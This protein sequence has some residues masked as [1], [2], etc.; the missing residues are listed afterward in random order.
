M[1]KESILTPVGR[2]VMGSFYKPQTTNI[3]GGP[4]TDKHGKPRVEYFFAI[5]IPKGTEN[6]WSQTPWG[7]KIYNAG[8]TGFPNGQT[9]SPTFAWKIVDGDSSIP[10]KKG[11]KPC[12]REG[13]PGNWVL[14]FNSGFA[15][16]ICDSTGK[17]SSLPEGAI[18]PGDYIQ[19]YG[20]VSD[21]GSS[22]QPG[23]FL[24]HSHV[25]LIGYG[26]RIMTGIDPASIGFGGDLPP[27]ASL[28]PITQ[29]F[30]PEVRNLINKSPQPQLP[31]YP[32]ILN[33]NGAMLSPSI[34]LLN[35]EK[36]KVL[37]SLAAG[38]SYEQLIK[39]GW[40]D[41]LLLQRG[42]MREE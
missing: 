42:M 30:N 17:I 6:H 41:E 32:N 34:P 3:E 27:G 36:R 40:T 21:N 28:T 2:F 19:V 13:Y 39:N 23:V 18:N 7:A 25:A 38:V 20:T 37:T 9:Q 16:T 35:S 29:G 24:N 31:T 10:N 8:L 11:R 5:A 1:T 22:Q 33:P 26:E 4:L 14:S 15:P 12:E